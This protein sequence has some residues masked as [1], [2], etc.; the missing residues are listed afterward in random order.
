PVL[1]GDG[2]LCAGTSG[3]YSVTAIPGATSYNWTIPTGG[4]IVSGQSTASIVVDWLSAPGGNVCVSAGSDCGPSPQQCF[5]VVVS[6]QPTAQAGSDAAICGSSIGL[7]ATNSVSGS[8]GTWSLIGGPGTAVFAD[9]ANP[10]SSVSVSQNGSYAFAWTE[11]NST[12]TD[13][14]TVQIAFNAAPEAVQIVPDCDANNQNY[15]ITFQIIGGTAPFAVSGGVVTGNVFVSDPIPSGQ[16]FSFVVTDANNC[17]SQPVGGAFNCNCSTFAG[18]MNQQ[19]LSACEGGSVNAQY[20]GGAVLDGNDVAAY[21]LH[22]NAGVFLGTVWAQN[23]TGAFTFQPG[24]VY[25]NTYYVSYVVGDALNGFPDPADPCLSV[26]TGQPVVFY[27]NPV[28]N[29]GIDQSACGLSQAIN[30]NGSTG[31]WSVSASPVGGN[32]QIDNPAS[33]AAN[34]LASLFGAYTLTWTLTQNGCSDTDDV[35]LNFNDAPA[36]GVITETCDAT[37]E[38]YQVSFDVTGGLAPYSINGNLLAL[39]SYLSPAIPSGT[40]YVFVLTDANGCS[41]AP[42]TGI[43]DCNCSSNAGQMS[44]QT[45]TACQGETVAAQPQGGSVLDGNDVLAY[46]LHTGA[47]NTLGTVVAQNQTG[48][49]AFQAGMVYGQTYYVSAVVGNN[50]A[51]FPDPNDPC[52][53]VA[54]GQPVVFLENPVA[55][56]G[57]D[58]AVCS[59]SIGL[60]A[61]VGA[62]NGQWSLV[63]GA[64]TAVFANPAAPATN[65]LVNNYGTYRFAWTETNGICTDADTVLVRFQETPS[66]ANIVPLCNSTNTQFT[67]SFDVL[68]GQTPYAVTGLSGTFSGNTFTSTP[69]VENSIYLFSVTDVNGCVS[70]VSTGSHECNCTTN[71]GNMVLTPAVF[72]ANTPASA[73]WN[74]NA[75]LDGDDAVQFILHTL[76]TNSVGTVLATANQPVF[77][78]GAGLQTGVTYYISAVV[79]NSA[80][81]TVDLTDPCL[82]VTPCAPVQWKPMPTASLSGDAT[83]CAGGSSTLTFSGTGTFPL[84]VTYQSG[85]AGAINQTLVNAQPFTLNVSPANTTTYTLVSV[86]DGTAPTCSSVLNQSVT[87]AVNQPVTAGVALAPTER[88]AG[89]S[90]TIALGTLLT[91]NDPGGQWTDVSVVP[92]LPGTFNAL[93]GTFLPAA[94]P[95]GTYQFRYTVPALAPCQDASA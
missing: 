7:N 22:S 90:P 56:A 74:N 91:G 45:L 48:V 81:G 4:V 65:V 2:V 58:N 25:G 73:V 78:F 76:P 75:V 26:S 33:P 92:A 40:P 35:V 88:C 66:V 15:T 57:T 85:S 62:F 72:C 42:I 47:G 29:A 18:Q 19:A 70:D 41:P 63:S 21:I 59:L 79:G 51:G 49:F 46:V 16:T 30:G 52:F 6:A 28:A 44:A 94:N 80:G 83:I 5:P 8:V 38:N 67:L 1:S 24:M 89:P 95:A 64:G 3:S 39:S 69:L 32:I 93:S 68:G 60:Q 11:T 27:Q 13:T 77:A 10:N 36:A 87:V 61:A 84:Q 54:Q 17:T 55:N 23:T 34:V 43:Y 82:S 14:D 86:S 9:A 12:C 50:T 20:L 31:V 37:N 53:S 71:A